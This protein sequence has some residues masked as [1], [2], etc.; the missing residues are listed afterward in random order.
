MNDDVRAFLDE[1]PYTAYLSTIDLKGFPHTVPVWFAV[2]GDDLISSMTTNRTRLK[3]I[4]ANPRA[5]M[6]IGG[7]HDD[8][9]GYLFQGNLTID[10][11]PDFVLLHKVIGRYMNEDGITK[12]MERVKSEQRIILR[13][14][15]TKII[16]V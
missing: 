8:R 13:L 5:S 2:D 15:P 10:D 16:E 7:N 11:D 6:T 3:F 14:S 9:A 1:K 4:Q 12:F